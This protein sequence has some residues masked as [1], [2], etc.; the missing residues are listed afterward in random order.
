LERLK[1]HADR[2]KQWKEA[3]NDVEEFEKAT[4]KL[5]TSAWSLCCYFIVRSLTQA[6]MPRFLNMNLFVKAMQFCS[7]TI[8][9]I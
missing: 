2:R 3:I 1:Y 6:T 7:D 5:T 9:E 4:K 8:R